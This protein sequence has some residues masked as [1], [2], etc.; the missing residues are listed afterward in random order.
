MEKKCSP[1]SSSSKMGEAPTVFLSL[2]A[3]SII[4]E[5]KRMTCSVITAYF[6]Q[7]QG[8][9][10]AL[11]WV[12]T[13]KQSDTENTDRRP[14]IDDKIYNSSVAPAITKHSITLF[15]LTDEKPSLAVHEVLNSEEN[16]WVEGELDEGNEFSS[17]SKGQTRPL[18]LI[19]YF[20]VDVINH[21]SE[22][23]LPTKARA[24]RFLCFLIYFL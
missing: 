20:T 15:T 24:R 23:L 11:F 17:T 1:K 6:S 10:K 14:R 19:D 22:L 12:I 18:I 8:V 21:L 2:A 16:E 4:T 9:T 5:I 13:P 7:I 3:S